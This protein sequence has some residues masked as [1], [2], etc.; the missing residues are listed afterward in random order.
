MEVDE[1]Q[2][3]E[4]SLKKRKRNS[5][6][7]TSLPQPMDSKVSKVEVEASTESPKGR[8]LKKVRKSNGS[9]TESRKSSSGKSTSDKGDA[10]NRNEVPMELT[11]VPAK[12]ERIIPVKDVSKVKKKRSYE[13]RLR[14]R[15]R[16]K[17]NIKLKKK[18]SVSVTET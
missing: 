5:S 7:G 11:P 14:R 9:K 12:A 6:I 18:K 13:A 1:P 17:D 16:V 4:S 10:S 2:V 8:S 15:K 3:Q